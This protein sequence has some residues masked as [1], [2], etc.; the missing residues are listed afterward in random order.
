MGRNLEL[1]DL[2]SLQLHKFISYIFSCQLCLGVSETVV[3]NMSTLC[4]SVVMLWSL[5]CDLVM[6]RFNVKSVGREWCFPDL[7]PLGPILEL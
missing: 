2:I 7:L 6:G 1:N 3:L 5:P 4:W